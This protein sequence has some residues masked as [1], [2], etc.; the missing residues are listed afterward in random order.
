M[1]DFTTGNDI[2][3]YR[4]VEEIDAQPCANYNLSNKEIAFIESMI[5][6]I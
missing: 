1:Q 6:P 3:W 5:K 2:D 4:N